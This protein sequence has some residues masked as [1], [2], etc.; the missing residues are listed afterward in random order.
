[1]AVLMMATMQG[2]TPEDY[3]AIN[4]ELNFPDE[5]PDGLLAHHAGKVEGGMQIVDVWESPEKFEAFMAGQLGPAGERAGVQPQ[6]TDQR[7]AEVHN[8]WY[9]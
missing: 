9:G 6:P 4:R 7:M 2:M 1:M 8:R 5:V 3:D